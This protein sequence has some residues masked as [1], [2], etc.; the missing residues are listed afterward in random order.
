MKKLLVN[1]FCAVLTGLVFYV[2]AYL[3]F[4]NRLY[5]GVAV[6]FLTLLIWRLKAFMDQVFGEARCTVYKVR[7]RHK[8]N[9]NSHSKKCR[10]Y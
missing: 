10:S 9:G 2:A 7:E 6:L 1:I 8:Q 4:S 3:A 5:M